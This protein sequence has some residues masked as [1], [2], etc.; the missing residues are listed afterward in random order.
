MNNS[1]IAGITT[2]WLLAGAALGAQP[3][4]PL[5]REEP[6]VQVTIK[7]RDDARDE[8]KREEEASA[9]A[10]DP[11][12]VIVAMVNRH[13]ITRAQLDRRVSAR[14]RGNAPG[15]LSADKP[16]DALPL[17]ISG[18]L[19][20]IQWDQEFEYDDAVREEEGAVV[21]QWMEQMMLAD[22]ARRQGLVVSD[23]EFR[24]RLRKVD[25]E[26]RLASTEVAGMLD[27]MGMQREELEGH[28]YDAL[29]IEKLLARFVALNFDDAYLH[30]RYE[31]NPSL[32]LTPER[33]EIAHFTIS[34]TGNESPD[35]VK[36][37]KK[38]AES[39]AKRLENG[40][41]P[42]VLFDENNRLEFGLFGAVVTWNIKN[43]R[44]HPQVSAEIARLKEGQVTDV[45]EAKRM[46]GSLVVTESLHVVKLLKI[47]P[48]TG[49]TFETA[50][51]KLRETAQEAA[52]AQLLR[53]LAEAR[54]HKRLMNL[55]GLPPEKLRKSVEGL[56]DRPPIKLHM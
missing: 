23:A 2:A 42:Q 30:T 33:H 32:Y 44:L 56:G 19:E 49:L 53:M 41:S 8:K 28:I 17:P 26:F 13:T 20:I 27:S 48:A 31:Q 38:D 1:A 16:G 5:I 10:P 35:A 12:T 40:E 11:E 15:V 3:V 50:L 39:I 47:H 52:R 34:L 55:S 14:L 25:D 54:T 36:R 7:S 9:P 29:L 46:Q 21:Q 22:E 45:I 6:K 43:P 51:P 24:D 37:Q 4:A 18:D